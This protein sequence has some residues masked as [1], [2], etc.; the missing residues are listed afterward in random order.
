M[1]KRNI[2]IDDVLPDCV[3]SAVEE[4]EELLRE[5]IAEN[6]ADKIPLLGD[7]DYSGRVHEI[8]DGA[9][10]IYTAEIEGAWFLHGSDLEEAYENAGVGDN[11]RENNG[12]AAIYF[13]IYEKVAEWYMN[14][15]EEIF[16]DATKGE[17]NDG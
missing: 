11:P 14:N 17:K 3:E 8:V 5:Y 15:A 1:T 4:V 12:G 6:E 7:L 2:E 13:Y 10:P 9:C 16:E